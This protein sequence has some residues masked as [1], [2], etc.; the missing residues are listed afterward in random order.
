MANPLHHAISS[1][2]RWGGDPRQYLPIH[3]WFDESKG[4]IPDFRHRAIRHHS[5]GIA[6]AVVLFEPILV[7]IEPGPGRHK[8]IPVRWVGEQHVVEDLG[9]I[10]TAADWLRHMQPQAWMTRARKLSEELENEH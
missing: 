5:E 10:P 4:W 6:E 8:L 1:S 7:E 9:R 3:E 2:R